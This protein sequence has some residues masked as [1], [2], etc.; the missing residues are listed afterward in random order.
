MNYKKQL[1]L[2]GSAMAPLLMIYFGYKYTIFHGI[3]TLILIIL[4]IVDT[5]HGAIVFNKIYGVKNQVYKE[6]WHLMVPWFER[7]IV[8]DL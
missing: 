4:F 5:G 2:T 7:P 6:G 8:Y 1:A 3:N